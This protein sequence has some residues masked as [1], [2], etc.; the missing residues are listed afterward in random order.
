M[1][2]LGHLRKLALPGGDRAAREPWRIATAWL[3][4]HAAAPL[5][6]QRFGSH[7]LFNAVSTL[8]SDRDCPDSSAAGRYFDLAAALLGICSENG[9]EAQAP[10]ML[11][12][13][14]TRPLEASGLFELK[15]RELSLDPLLQELAS[16]RDPKVGASLFHGVL[17]EALTA[18]VR[19]HC[20]QSGLDTV[21]LSG[22]CFA[23]RWLAQ[24]LPTALEQTGLRVLTNWDRVPPGDGG[25]SLGQAWVAACALE[26]EPAR[27]G[28]KSCA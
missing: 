27:E 22:G 12:S 23:N 17:V 24:G 15:G 13:L 3:T 19:D 21:A 9:Y 10:M 16:C 6:R 4:R 14:C 7:P 5:A 1:A 11:E 18:W 25:L 26:Q 20:E 28:F 8:A 2:R